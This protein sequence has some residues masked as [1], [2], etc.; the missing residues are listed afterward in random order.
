MNPENPKNK[1]LGIALRTALLSWLVTIATVLIFVIAIIPMQKQAVLENLESKARGL[2]A[3]L[4]NVAAGAA[5]NE[6]FSSVV[7]HCKEMLDGDQALDYLVI[8]KNDG[9]SL[10]ND[11]SGW[12]SETNASKTWRPDIRKPVSGIGVVPLLNRRVFYY[13]QPFDYSG[14]QWGWIHVGLSLDR[15]DRRVAMVYQRTAMLAI[16]CII[17]SLLA[18]VFYARHLVDPILNLRHVVR[19]VASGNLAARAVVDRGDELGSLA[20]SINVMTDS[21]RRR[22]LILESMRFAAQKFLSTPRWEAVITEVLAKIGEAADVS[23]VHVLQKEFAANGQPKLKQLCDWESATCP[24]VTQAAGENTMVTLGTNLGGLLPLFEQGQAFTRLP[25]GFPPAI[26]QIIQARRIK[27][28]MVVPIMVQGS[29]WGVFSLVDCRQERE[30]TDSEQDSFRAMA[31][32]F[33]AAIE[34]Q[35]IQ[36]ALVLAKEAAEAASQAKSQFLA[37]MSHEI[38]TPITG[39]IGML[40]L[41]QRTEMDKRQTRY[42][43]NAFTSAKT[44]LTVIGDVLD[45]SKIEAGKMELDEYPFDPVEV[46]DTVVRLF[47]ERAEDKGIE[48][49][50]RVSEAV[51]RQLRG[52]SNRLRQVLVNLVGNAVKFT[53]RGEVVVSCERLDTAAEATTLRFEIRDTGCGIAPEKQTLIFDP[54]AQADNSMTRKYGGTGLGLTISRQFCELMGGSI[55]VQ[56]TLG[57][58]ST[59]CLTLRFKND[60]AAAAGTAAHLLDLRSLRVLVVDDCATVREINREWIAA[61]QGQPEVAADATQALEML[62]SAARVGQPFQVA[63][64]DWKMPGMDGLT[65]GGMIKKE[66]EL[67]NTGLVLLSSFTQ[68]G[69]FDKIIAAGFAAFLPKPAGKSD[70][71]DAIVTAANGEFKKAG[72]TAPEKPGMLPA[73]STLAAGTVLLAEDNEINREVATEMLSALGYPCRWVRNGREAV[74]IWRRGQIDLILMDCQMPEMDGYEAT[75]AIRLEEGSHTDKRHIPIVAL[76]A[77]ATKGDCDRCLGAGMDDYL[78]KPMDPELLAATLAKWLAR[79]VPSGAVPEA[80]MSAE[81]IDYPSLLRRCLNKPELAAR[82]VRKFVE[83]AG[84]DVEAIAKAVQQNDPAALA[85]W[86]HRVKGASANVSAESL[87]QAAAELETLGRSGTVNSAGVLV[88]HLQKELARL[89]AAAAA[90]AVKNQASL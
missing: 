74:E 54:F 58:G 49:V 4:H 80:T 63:V 30:W 51:P 68:Q 27:A 20:G 60:P 38:R 36:T 17:I 55:G 66:N 61:W 10:I 71:Y 32:M 41:L 21:L 50:Y 18:S 56:S 85:A 81:P 8:T 52:D 79:K 26:R 14:I 6:D 25:A 65:L 35:Q 22:D 44:L 43:A 48:L 33:G 76:T 29:W 24:P 39:V 90:L 88:E 89:K 19:Q 31:D 15:Y 78:T 12:R 72:S 67:K 47:A 46:V 70:L 3:S 5:V 87:R 62:R 73:V 45:F 16:V 2:A 13:S 86:A 84:P 9:F 11:R 1:S 34:R 7:D 57:S 23:R 42:A 83:Q 59:F 37:N 75:R 69:G 77:H 82:L 64:L 53:N 28:F 40:Q